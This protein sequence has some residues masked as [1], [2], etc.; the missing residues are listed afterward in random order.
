MLSW[1]QRTAQWTV[2]TLPFPLG[3]SGG[4]ARETTDAEAP[5]AGDEALTVPAGAAP[6]GTAP[7]ETAPAGKNPGRAR[8]PD[9]HGSRH[10]ASHE[11][12]VAP[13]TRGRHAAPGRSRR[14]RTEHAD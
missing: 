4:P 6:A 11:R 14:T 13:S 9:N 8:T 1:A 12:A 7:S 5:Q 2:K 3:R 10:R